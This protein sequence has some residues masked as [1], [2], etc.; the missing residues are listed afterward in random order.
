MVGGG[1]AAGVELL[2]GVK[3]VAKW[4]AKELGRR[5]SSMTPEQAEIYAKNSKLVKQLANEKMHDPTALEQRAIKLSQGALENSRE[6]SKKIS[7]QRAEIIARAKPIR[8]EPSQF[9]GSVVEE[10]LNRMAAANPKKSSTLEQLIRGGDNEG[11]VLG[12]VEKSVPA[13]KVVVGG[14][15]VER[16]KEMAADANKFKEAY[17]QVGPAERT[18]S[19]ANRQAERSL[20]KA[21]EGATKGDDLKKLNLIWGKRL[22]DEKTLGRMARSNPSNLITS[23]SVKVQATAQRLSP[24]LRSTQ[25]AFGVSKTLLPQAGESFLGS[26]LASVGR[27]AI[28]VAGP[29][30]SPSPAAN[31]GLS[32]AAILQALEQYG[33]KK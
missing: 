31:A 2:G 6:A 8:L 19:I 12:Q 4:G 13:Q 5:F 1:L 23:P 32:L 33:E 29:K 10:E 25:E 16:L 20:R 24:E 27:K 7:K 9:K 21:L 3:D 15:G 30:T 28:E 22:S 26:A 17:A 14:G 11:M 18:A